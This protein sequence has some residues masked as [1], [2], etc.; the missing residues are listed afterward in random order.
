MG[1]IPTSQ[2]LARQV[3]VSMRSSASGLGST[4][5]KSDIFTSPSRLG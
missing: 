3:S 2:P 1:S 4:G 5:G